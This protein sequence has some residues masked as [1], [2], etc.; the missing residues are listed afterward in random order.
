MGGGK[1]SFS[2]EATAK[3][4]IGYYFTSQTKLA[5]PYSAAFG[6]AW[7]LVS[8]TNINEKNINIEEDQKN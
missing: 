3:C 1:I 2:P 7:E 8:A 4:P 5:A 6:S